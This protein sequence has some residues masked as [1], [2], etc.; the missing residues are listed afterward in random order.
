M[1]I[2]KE[3]KTENID[4]LTNED[5]LIEIRLEPNESL[6][7]YVA[8]GPYMTTGS[9]DLNTL[10]QLLDIVKSNNPHVLILVLV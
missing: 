9:T 5:G 2:K 3:F 1:K 4:E 8:S 6:I 7:C 10:N